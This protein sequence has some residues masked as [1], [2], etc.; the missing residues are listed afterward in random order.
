[1]RVSR[2]QAHQLQIGL[3]LQQFQDILVEHFLFLLEL[4]HVHVRMRH[5]QAVALFGVKCP[6]LL[7]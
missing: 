7:L 3:L 6:I 4:A 5:L 1:M 2:L